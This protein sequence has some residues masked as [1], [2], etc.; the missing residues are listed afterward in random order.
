MQMDDDMLV[1]P[2]CVERLVETLATCG[3]KAAV[4]PALVD[5]HSGRPVYRKPVRPVLLQA[6][7]YRLMNGPAGYEPGRINRAGDPVGIDPVAGPAGQRV[8]DVDSCIGSWRNGS[9]GDR[10]DR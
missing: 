10:P 3:P 7:Y 5:L 9:P 6:V 1:A 8:Y 2:D 4:A